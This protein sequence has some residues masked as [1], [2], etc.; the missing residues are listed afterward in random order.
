MVSDEVLAFVQCCQ[1]TVGVCIE[2]DWCTQVSALWT[3]LAGFPKFPVTAEDRTTAVG[4]TCRLAR[5]F[6]APRPMKPSA[7][8]DHSARARVDALLSVVYQRYPDCRLALGVIACDLGLTQSYLSRVLVRETG[9]AFRTHLNGLRILSAAVRLQ[10]GGH[11][12][13]ET[14]FAVGYLNT[15]ELDRQFHRWF[16]LS[17]TSF[18]HMGAS[19]DYGET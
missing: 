13:K 3:C 5:G 8:R 17:P 7:C 19:V 18:T 6:V 9:H 1:L 2:Q 10:D 11:Q 4:A 14:A 12:V 15:G 16:G